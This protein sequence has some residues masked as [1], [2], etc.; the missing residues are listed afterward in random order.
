MRSSDAVMP[1]SRRE[2]PAM[3][4]VRQ[5]LPTDRIEGA[6][7]DVT[8]KLRESAVLQRVRPGDQIAITAG[9]RGI[10]DL[11]SL[12]SGIVDAD[13]GA[14]PA[15]A[16][17]SSLPARWLA[18]LRGGCVAARNPDHAFSGRCFMKCATPTTCSTGRTNAIPR[19]VSLSSAERTIS[20]STVSTWSE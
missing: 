10:G 6:A 7:A 8:S 20:W 4:R 19:P 12:L 3:A 1:F 18:L 2:L 5:A 15:A 17:R 16:P 9:S 13:L 14:H 11:V